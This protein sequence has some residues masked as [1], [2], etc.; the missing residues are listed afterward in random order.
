[1]MKMVQRYIQFKINEVIIIP[2]LTSPNNNSYKFPTTKLMSAHLKVTHN[3]I[4]EPMPFVLNGI[5]SISE[6]L[7]LRAINKTKMFLKIGD[8]TKEVYNLT[9]R[10]LSTG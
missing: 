6:K 2:E 9:I 7:R 4:E 3:L 10:F 8:D 1:M 5:F